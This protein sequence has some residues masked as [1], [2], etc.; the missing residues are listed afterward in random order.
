MEK[1][2]ERLSDS[3]L[4]KQACSLIDEISMT[5]KQSSRKM[6]DSLVSRT[7]ETFSDAFDKGKEKVK[8]KIIEKVSTDDKK[9]NVS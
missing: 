9:D 2:D 8:Q 7:V 1:K 5:I 6:F 3:E 4:T